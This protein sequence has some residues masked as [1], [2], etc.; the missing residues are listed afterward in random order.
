MIV[1]G[2]HLEFEDDLGMGWLRTLLLGDVGNRLD[3]ED[4]ERTLA[5]VKRRQAQASA[6]I[7]SSSAQ[8][9][10]L[11]E[12]LG[13]QKLAVEALSRF[14]V[15][16]GIVDERE[17]DEFIQ[18]VDAEDGAVDG[19]LA[20]EGSTGRLKLIIPDAGRGGA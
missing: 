1:I 4:A 13:R 15:S 16:R 12:E 20:F 8:I 3:I 10:A 11:R 5:R 9:A 2:D 18:D 17:L 19:K 7:V 6:S 14:L